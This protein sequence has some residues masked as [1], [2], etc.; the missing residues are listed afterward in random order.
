MTDMGAPAD[1]V[2]TMSS[3]AQDGFDTAIADGASPA[4]AFDAAGD[5]VDTAFGGGPEGDMGPGD[6]AG[7]P[8]PMDGEPGGPG[9]EPGPMDGGPG[10][11]GDM[12]PPMDGMDEMHT[13]MD[14]AASH[15][16][17]DGDM[18]PPPEGDQMGPPPEGRGAMDQAFGDPAGGDM[19]PPADAAADPMGAAL[20]NAAAQSD[21]GAAGGQAPAAAPMADMPT[22]GGADQGMPDTHEDD[23]GGGA[24]G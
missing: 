12:P 22:D 1:M 8:G 7:E 14:D 15:G 21:A 4:E 17:A 5:S 3:A 6:M 9:G 13:H 18:G 20:D 19:A 10:G 16:P 23:Q 24:I 2:D 11:P